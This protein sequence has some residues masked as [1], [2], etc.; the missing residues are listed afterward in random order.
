MRRLDN[1]PTWFMSI[2]DL[3]GGGV[4]ESRTE[5]PRSRHEAG[6]RVWEQPSSVGDIARRLRSGIVMH[7]RP[8]F[9][10]L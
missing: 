3:G 5:S 4:V 2:W 10:P 7:L 6:M 9:A 8:Q 1:R